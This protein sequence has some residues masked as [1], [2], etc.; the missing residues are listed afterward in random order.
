MPTKYDIIYEDA[1]RM[2]ARATVRCQCANAALLAAEQ[3]K[4]DAERYYAE[5]LRMYRMS[6]QAFDAEP[7]IT[8]DHEV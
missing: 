6:K 8:H 5:A 1:K 7:A 4:R 2:L 3:G